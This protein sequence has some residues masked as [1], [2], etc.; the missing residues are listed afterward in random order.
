MSIEVRAFAPVDED[1]VVA[2][3]EEAGLTRPWND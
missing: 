3:W 1:A 2:L